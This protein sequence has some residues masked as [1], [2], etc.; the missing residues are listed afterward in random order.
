MQKLSIHHTKQIHWACRRGMRE[1]DM[2]IM[3]FFEKHFAYLS[4]EEKTAFIEL[5]NY[6][7][8]VIFRWLMWQESPPNV[9]LKHLVFL[10]R[11]SQIDNLAN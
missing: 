9:M 7:D 5:L 8:P 2:L 4:D 11:E 6:D 3:P 10:I 1:L